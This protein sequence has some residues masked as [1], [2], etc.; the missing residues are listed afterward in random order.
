MAS[1]L[2][3]IRVLDFSRVF[4][5]PAATQI[6][7]DLGADVIKVEEPTIGDDARTYGVDPDKLVLPVGASPPYL[8][9][10][11]NKR[12]IGIDLRQPAGRQLASRLARSVDV[13]VHNFRPGLMA[14]WGLDYTDLVDTNPR[15]IFCDFSAYGPTGPLSHMGAND[16]ALQAFSGLMSITGAANGEP[17]RAGTSVVD[18]HA[19]VAIACAI[20]AA[21]FHRQRTGEGQRVESS[22][23]LSSSHLMGYFYTEYWLDG[24]IRKP[25]G[26]ANHLTVPNQAFPTADGSAV[27]IAST[28]DMWRRCALALDSATL[29]LP[30]F[31]TADDRLRHREKLV[32]ALSAVTSRMTSAELVRRL[33]GTRIVVSK[34]NS[35]GEAA[36]SEQLVAS[37]T[38]T[39]FRYDDLEIKSVGPPFTLEK[40]PAVVRHSPPRLG[41]DTATILREFGIDDDEVD[42]YRKHGALGR[43]T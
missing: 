42:T 4:A 43:S 21:L 36:E 3:G 2:D 40:T 37:G 23:L 31:C 15:I 25:M 26:S 13:V 7:G 24:T 12:S 30:E 22:L 14:G 11:R 8:A 6:L 29:D 34:L 17:V 35:I 19:G 1:V 28:D 18:L 9:L 10:N 5:G 41:A 16:I 32:A 27:I 20:I 33:G 39:H 38:I